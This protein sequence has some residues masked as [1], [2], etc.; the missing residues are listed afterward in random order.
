M[1]LITGPPTQ[2]IEHDSLE[3]RLPVLKLHRDRV[4]H[5]IHAFEARFEMR[6]RVHGLRLCER[7]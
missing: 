2:D 5:Q 3:I 1:L 7:R 6:V 4:A